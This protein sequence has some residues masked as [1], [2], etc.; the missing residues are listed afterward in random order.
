MFLAGE[1]DESFGDGAFIRRG[2]VSIGDVDLCVPGHCFDALMTS[3]KIP[4]AY[5]FHNAGQVTE[6]V[7]GFLEAGEA[8]CGYFT[9]V[10]F[11]G[12]QVTCFHSGSS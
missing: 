5:V 12:L 9:R 6:F 7:Q 2:C 11:C 10:I 8:V 1:E 4:G 3:D